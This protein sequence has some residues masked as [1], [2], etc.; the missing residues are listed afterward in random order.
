MHELSV[1]TAVVDTALRH[2]GGRQVTHVTL[3]VGRLRQVIPDSLALW[4][5]ICT[6]ETACAGSV[7]EQVVVPA[8]VR[9]VPC[10]REWNPEDALF[11]C[12]VCGGA[13]EVVTGNELE[14]ESIE[15]EEGAQC[16]A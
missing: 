13:G 9:C 4:W 1:A 10:G 6:R 15:V 16:I 2:A 7:L 12:A 8:S 11:R 3:R 5:D 14:V